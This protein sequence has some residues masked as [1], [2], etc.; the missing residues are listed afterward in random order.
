M[1]HKVVTNIATSKL[2]VTLAECYTAD[3]LPE[4][5]LQYEVQAAAHG[6]CLQLLLANNTV[7]VRFVKGLT[8]ICWAGDAS[9]DARL[10]VLYE[11]SSPRTAELLASAASLQC[12]Y[13]YSALCLLVWEE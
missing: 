4:V 11:I 2:L 6:L 9:G 13:K 3:M 8:H 1:Q 12:R 5:V 7:G 10:H